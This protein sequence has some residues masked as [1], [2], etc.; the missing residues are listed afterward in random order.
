MMNIS[1]FRGGP[2]PSLYRYGDPHVPTKLPAAASHLEPV[3]AFFGHHIQYVRSGILYLH[4]TILFFSTH[5]PVRLS[6]K[7]CQRTMIRTVGELGEGWSVLA[8]VDRKWRKW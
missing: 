5:S 7:A 2:S 4:L 3:Q 6:I 1:L 8:T